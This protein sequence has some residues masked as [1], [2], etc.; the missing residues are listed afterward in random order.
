MNPKNKS[1]RICLRWINREQFEIW[2]QFNWEGTQAICAFFYIVQF[3]YIAISHWKCSR[4]DLEPNPNVMLHRSIAIRWNERVKKPHTDTLS[5]MIQSLYLI[6]QESCNY[7]WFSVWMEKNQLLTG[8]FLKQS[9]K[10]TNTMY[11]Y[12]D[13]NRAK[14]DL[15]FMILECGQ[16][17]FLW[18]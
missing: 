10:L 7:C 13:F 18:F 16:V 8:F 11:I 17:I 1:Q 6:S 5:P 15:I 12:V 14:N 3:T 2:W 4:Y 9:I